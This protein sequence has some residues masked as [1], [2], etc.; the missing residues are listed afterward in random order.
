MIIEVMCTQNLG[1]DCL[2]NF[3]KQGHRKGEGH[4]R[5]RRQS[6]RK[7]WMAKHAIK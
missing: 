1:Q 4:D 7:A 5:M 3:L 2:L 6:G